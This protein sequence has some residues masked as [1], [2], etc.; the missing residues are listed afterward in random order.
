[1]KDTT[2]IPDS[3]ELKQSNISNAGR[4][5][6]AKIPIKANT[7]LGEYEGVFVPV[8]E[9][10]KWKKEDKDEGFE[11]GW[12]LHDYWGNKKRPKGAKLSE[13]K[14]I[15]YVDGRDL[16]RSN[17]LRYVNHPGRD[18]DENI[19]P[20]QMKDKIYYM[21]NKDIAIG[22]E[23]YVNYGPIFFDHQS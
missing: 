20:Y 1:M 17:Y 19:T 18:G 8:E 3:F 23:L 13:S 15:G 10:E 9:F 11:Y 22:D 6:F 5:I 12:E 7:C 16:N 4:G 14:L 21:T 2:E